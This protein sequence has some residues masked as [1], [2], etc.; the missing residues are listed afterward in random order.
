METKSSLK[1]LTI[2]AS[3]AIIFLQG[4]PEIVAEIDKA[5]PSM[6]IATSP[7]VV[8]ILTVCAGIVAIYGRFRA[9]TVL[10]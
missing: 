7:L 8:K 5:I 3:A 2:Q 10:K 6:D 9:K 4:L 1:S